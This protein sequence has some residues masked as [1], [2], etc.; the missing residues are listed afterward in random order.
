MRGVMLAVGTPPKEVSDW[1]GIKL[2]LGKTGKMS[3]KRRIMTLDY[4]VLKS[5]KRTVKVIGKLINSVHIDKVQQIS[6][7]A[8]IFYAWTSG[9]LMD[10]D[11]DFGK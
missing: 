3:I 9:V 11:E 4:A 1:S 2:W 7:G 10:L 5:K 8:S 6:K